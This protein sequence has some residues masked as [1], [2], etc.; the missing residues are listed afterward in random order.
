MS[1]R[2]SRIIIWSVNGIHEDFDPYNVP[3]S[4]SGEWLIPQ[5]WNQGGYD[6][7]QLPGGSRL[8]RVIQVTHADSSLVMCVKC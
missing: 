5:K 2:I 8:L 3:E 7:L 4:L 6:F 1:L